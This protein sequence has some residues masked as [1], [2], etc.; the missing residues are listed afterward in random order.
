MSPRSKTPVQIRPFN[1][2]SAW[3]PRWLRTWLRNFSFQVVVME[4]QGLKSLAP[5]RIVYCTMEVEG[6]EKLQ[7]DQAEASRPQWVSWPEGVAVTSQQDSAAHEHTQNTPRQTPKYLSCCHVTTMMSSLLPEVCRV[8]IITLSCAVNVSVLPWKL[9]K[10][11]GFRF[12][13]Y[14]Q[15][16][17]VVVAGS[18]QKNTRTYVP[19]HTDTCAHSV[20]VCNDVQ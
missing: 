20:K 4:V 17:E 6:G 18:S 9:G 7:T 15:E 19:T 8:K 16:V 10:M 14:P 12:A 3:Q 2:C 5:N 13:C 11:R 1:P